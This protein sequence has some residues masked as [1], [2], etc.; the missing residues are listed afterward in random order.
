MLIKN[1]LLKAHKIVVTFSCFYKE[2]IQKIG[3]LLFLQYNKAFVTYKIIVRIY[4][5]EI[6]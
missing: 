1:F 6:Y 4:K 3:N 2:I 5:Y